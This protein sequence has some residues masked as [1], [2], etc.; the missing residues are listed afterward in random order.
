MVELDGMSGTG[1]IGHGTGAIGHGTGA[2]GHGTGAIELRVR[3]TMLGVIVGGTALVIKKG[4][5]LYEV[6][7]LRTLADGAPVIFERVLHPDNEH[8][9]ETVENPVE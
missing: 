4:R 6:D 9:G 5:R 7:W 8:E 1:A 2:I 3:G